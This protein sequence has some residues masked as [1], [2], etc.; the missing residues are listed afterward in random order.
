MN[1]TSAWDSR[2]GSGRDCWVPCGG[3][4]GS[5][6]AGR[7]SSRPA[8]R[9]RSRLAIACWPSAR[10]SSPESAT[11]CQPVLASS[12]SAWPASN[13]DLAGLAE[14]R[15]RGLEAGAAGIAG[16]PGQGHADGQAAPGRGDPPELPED[17]LQDGRLQVDGDPLEQ[18]QAGRLRVEPGRAQPVR[19]RVAGEV[20]LDEPHA[21][22]VDAEPL[23]P[24]ELVPL[25]RGVVDL[26]PADTRLGVP[27]RAAVVAGRA[28]HDL[29]HAPI[30][31]ADD[32][33]VEER[34]ARGEVVVHPARR[35]DPPGRDVGG[36]G[37]VGGGI[38]VVG[39]DP[40][41][42]EPVCAATR[43]AVT[44]GP[45]S[46]MSAHC[47]MALIPSVRTAVSD[48]RAVWTASAAVLMSWATSSGWNVTSI[49]GPGQPRLTPGLAGM[50]SRVRAAPQRARRA[51]RDRQ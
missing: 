12:A 32:G 41:E 49:S 46:S 3:W 42:A 13:M 48:Q 45:P 8:E 40:G 19:D 1:A 30:E 37:L 4:N 44:E 20:G 7:A 28:D 6:P 43:R 17:V 15:H 22:R 33:P 27:E 16:R 10:W 2:A 26:E 38:T 34:G 50:G 18:E 51:D 11:S 5:G 29:P 35:G 9:R 36:H 21:G 39:S 31:R 47:A 25:G 14:R 23:E 24:L